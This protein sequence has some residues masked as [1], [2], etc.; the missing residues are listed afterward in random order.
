M[1]ARPVLPRAAPVDALKMS[2]TEPILCPSSRCQTGAILL[3]LVLPDGRVAYSSDRIVVDE[4][5]VDVARTGRS[6]EKR[7][8][9]STP[10]VQGACRQWTGS[11]CGVI[12]AVIEH[13]PAEPALPD[14]SIRPQ[15][16]WYAQNGAHACAVCL[17][18]I[19]DATA[20]A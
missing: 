15:C 17:S 20:E 12:D 19:T 18:V 1:P 5:F 13:L 11:R 7:F 14:C 4:E 16:R 9:F 6:P 3:G 10:C 2:A 8:R